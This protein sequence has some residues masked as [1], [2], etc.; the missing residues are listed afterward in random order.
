M[1]QYSQVFHRRGR[2][3]RI[4]KLDLRPR[5]R[6]IEARIN[7]LGRARDEWLQENCRRSQ[8]FEQIEEY[9]RGRVFIRLHRFP[10]R[11][12]VGILVGGI[13]NLPPD[14]FERLIEP[15]RFDVFAHLIHRAGD[16]GPRDCLGFPFRGSRQRAAVVLRNQRHEPAIEV[17]EIIRQIRIEDIREALSY[18]AVK[19]N[20]DTDMQWAFWDGIRGYEASK[21]DYL[22]G[23]IGNPEGKDKPNKKFYDPRVFL[24]EGEKSF[25]A[26][27]KAAYED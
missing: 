12:L 6:E 25:V 1:G 14:H 4:G 11:L 13:E 17:A 21:R 27:L 20:I 2:R 9:V 3:R 22:Q 8:R 24:R 23:Q 5:N 16:I 10:R 7:R 15:A 19:M 26:R 18:G